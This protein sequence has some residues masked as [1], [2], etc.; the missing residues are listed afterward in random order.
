MESSSS[1]SPFDVPAHFLKPK[2]FRDPLKT[3]SS[4]AQEEVVSAALPL[5]TA[6]LDPSKNPF[7]FNPHGIPGLERE[8][9]VEF[10]QEGLGEFPEEF[11]GIDSSRPWM[12]YWA[13]MALWVLGEDVS[14]YEES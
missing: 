3:E 2:A 1:G 8:Q 13:I 11:V 6:A 10:L 4:K 9:H 12:V 14:A 7:D 5:L